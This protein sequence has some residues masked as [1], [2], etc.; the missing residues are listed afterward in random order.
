MSSGILM[1]V[2]AQEHRT[3]K[4]WAEERDR[5]VAHLVTVEPSVRSS[6]RQAHRRRVDSRSTVAIAV[7]IATCAATVVP[8][9]IA[10]AGPEQGNADTA[11][12]NRTAGQPG[13]RGPSNEITD[14]DSGVAAGDRVRV[15]VRSYETAAISAEINAR[16]TRLPEREGDKFTKGDILVEF[17]CRRLLA[18]HSAARAVVQSR[19]A[20]FDTERQRLQ[21]KSTGTLSLEQARAELEKANAEAEGA[22]ARKSS[23]QI[24]APF[25][26]RVTEKAAQVHEIAQ[27]NQ[28]LI[29]VINERKLELM[30]MVPSAWLT[31][32]RTGTPFRVKFDETGESHGARVLQSTGVI[33]PVSQSARLIAELVD[34][35]AAVG[36]GMSG[37]AVFS[38][39][40]G[41]K[42]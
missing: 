9:A 31:R 33:D 30:L 16:I 42:C 22:D 3:T 19:Q 37:A 36:P 1:S 11:G 20:A 13:C 5:K 23:C 4:K 39:N 2:T 7:V 18:E 10:H 24:V 32:I 35:G 8:C 12:A 25:D 6:M 27:T 41:P 21:Y 34:P 17:D 26:G 38:L 14:A 40:E 28:P 29:R 15:V